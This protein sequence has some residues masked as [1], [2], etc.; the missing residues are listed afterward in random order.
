M[1]KRVQIP[2]K[3]HL[4]EKFV[5]KISLLIIFAYDKNSTV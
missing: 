2:R 1:L 4:F 5:L 3:E